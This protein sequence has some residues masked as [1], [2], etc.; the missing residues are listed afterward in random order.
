MQAVATDCR[1]A[2]HGIGTGLSWRSRMGIESRQSPILRDLSEES[3]GEYAR[4][5]RRAESISGTKRRNV[6][7]RSV[8]KG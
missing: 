4:V 5:L 3:S 2:E 1:R 7:A 6:H 8:S